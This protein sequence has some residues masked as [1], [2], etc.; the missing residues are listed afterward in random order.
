MAWLL[1]PSEGGHAARLRSLIRSG[2][3]L[4]VPGA[5]DAL[6]AL[7]AKREGFG[8]LYLSGA[9]LSASHGLPDLGLLTLEELL[10]ATRSIVHAADLPLIV[11]GDTGYGET[12]NVVRLVR[13][14]EEAGAAAVQIEDQEMPKRCGHLEGK[15][16]VPVEEM[17]SRLRAALHT[18]RDLLVI[19]RTDARG[20]T[21]VEDAIARARRYEALGVD[22]IFPEGLQTAE[23]FAALRQALRVPLLANMTEFGKTPYFSAA[24]FRELGYEVVIYPVSSLRLAAKAVAEGYRALRESGTLEGKLDRMLTRR[25]LYDVIHYDEHEEVARGLQEATEGEEGY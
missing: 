6:S 9:A 24:E 2:D 20:V 8:A 14:L 4:L 3:T 15:H 19:A 16:L 5:H 12:L 18:R 23:E 11:D 17:E 1:S 13:E 10:V 21:G 7:L 22:V 25:E